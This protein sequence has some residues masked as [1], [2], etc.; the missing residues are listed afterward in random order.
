M[1]NHLNKQPKKPQ[2]VV[3]LGAKGFIGSTTAQRLLDEKIAV[4]ALGRQELDLLSDNAG[5]KLSGLLK[6]DDSLV[7]I[8]AQAPVKNNAMLENNIRMMSAVCEALES[9]APA[10]VVY[11]SSDAVYADSSEPLTEDSCAEPG[12]LHGVMHLAREVM[13]VN[14]YSGPLAIIRPTLI[15]GE[16]DPHNG[17][18]PN[19]FRRLAAAGEEIVLFGEGEERRDHVLVDDVAD[20]IVRMLKHKSEGKLNAAT[21]GVTSFRKIAEMVVSY[22]DTPVDIKGSPRVGTMPHDGYRP[23]DPAQTH[24]AFPDFVYVDIADGI[25]RTNAS[26]TKQ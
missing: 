16:R 15:Y 4:L 25:Q 22:F 2:R 21:G 12:S 26:G 6:L 14:A 1:L 24:A 18:G 7:V 9:A 20:L 13:L 23:F 11:V 10:H 5:A 3:I 17:Y 19:R 8:S